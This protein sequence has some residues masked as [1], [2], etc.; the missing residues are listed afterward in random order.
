MIV[1]QDIATGCVNL[2]KALAQLGLNQKVLTNPLCLDPRVAQGLGG[3]FPKWTWAI[4][5]SL[6]FDPPTR[7]CPV[8]QGLQEVRT[9][10][11]HP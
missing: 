6:G 10:E 5:S 8:P 3:D 2:A 7:A 4:A 1:L 9:G 11:D